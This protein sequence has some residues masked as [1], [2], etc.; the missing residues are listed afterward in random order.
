VALHKGEDG[1]QRPVQVNPLLGE[2]NPV[3]GVEAV[4]PRHRLP[5]GPTPPTSRPGSAPR[6]TRWRS[7]RAGMRPSAW[8]PRPEA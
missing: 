1:R 7:A 2:A 8:T 6:W 5:D 4:L 3:S